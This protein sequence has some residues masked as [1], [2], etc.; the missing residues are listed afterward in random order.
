MYDVGSDELLIVAS[1][2][3]SAFD[4]VLGEPI[5]YKGEVLTQLTA[6]WLDRFSGWVD[7]HLVAVRPSEIV[8]R[9][10]ELAAS[11]DR[12]AGRAML[13]RRTKPLMVECVV[14]GYLSGSAWREYRRAGTLAG[15][16]LP[17]GLVESDRIEPA[18]FSPSTKATEGHDENI[19]YD[20]VVTEVGE[21]MAA[22]LRDLSLAIYGAGSTTALERGIIL[23]D[24]KFE[25]GVDA[26]G[27]LL[28][29]DEALTPDSSRFW[30]AEL[31]APGRGQPSLDKQPIRDHL[32]GQSGWDKTPPAPPLPREVLDESSRR[33][34]EIFERLTGV[35]LDDY[36]SPHFDSDSD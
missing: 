18:I 1:D 19:T 31:Y 10:P 7:H 5:P 23:A 33:Y 36:V 35:A 14:R 11:T 27:N 9:M 13:V 17:D 6:W 21:S 30:P 28:V 25:F 26:A 24:T 15:E 22:R 20:D 8:D 34:L 4:V 2:R 29:I 32:E 12:W 16:P 3:V